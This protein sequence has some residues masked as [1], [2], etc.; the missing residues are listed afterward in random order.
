MIMAGF[1]V[2]AILILL[3]GEPVYER[4]HRSHPGFPSSLAE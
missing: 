3:R 1:A 2:F 4:G